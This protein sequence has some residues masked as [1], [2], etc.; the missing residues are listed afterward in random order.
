MTTKHN[1]H[2]PSSSLARF[3]PEPC[4]GGSCTMRG[5]PAAATPYRAVAGL[6]HN[7]GWRTP[8]SVHAYMEGGPAAATPRQMEPFMDSP[9]TVGGVHLQASTPRQRGEGADR[10]TTHGDILGLARNGGRHTPASVH[11]WTGR[12]G[13]R[14]T[15]RSRSWT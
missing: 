8:A 14:H 6:T 12:V 9:V 7:G 5:V 1:H 3:S 11:V 15:A 4:A 2:R 13:R 10:R